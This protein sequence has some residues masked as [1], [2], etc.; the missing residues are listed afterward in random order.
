MMKIPPWFIAVAHRQSRWRKE[1]QVNFSIFQPFALSI[2][3]MF[4]RG[5]LIFVLNV[6]FLTIC[7][8]TLQLFS[9]NIFS[10][11]CWIILTNMNITFTGSLWINS[12]SFLLRLYLNM[13]RRHNSH[14]IFP[15]KKKITD[16][17][18][19]PSDKQA[20]QLGEHVTCIFTQWM[21]V[22]D[23]SMTYKMPQ[24]NGQ[25]DTGVGYTSQ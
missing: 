10:I 19:N 21:G 14:Y 15:I 5:K 23:R 13:E 6:Y 2:F 24:T 11:L 16:N 1:C 17:N 25:G 7:T 22:G 18:F 20:H 8:F 4:L 3:Q 12:I 9:S